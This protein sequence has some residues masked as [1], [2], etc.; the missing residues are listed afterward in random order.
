MQASQGL[1]RRRQR[2]R[3]SAGR[4][5]SYHPLP[6]DHPV[7]ASGI[8]WAV[9]LLVLI[10]LHTHTRL[11]MHT[12]ARVHTHIG[13]GACACATP[14][15]HTH[16]H[17][18]TCT[19]TLGVG[20]TFVSV[21]TCA[22]ACFPWLYHGCTTAAGAAAVGDAARRRAAALRGRRT[23]RARAAEEAPAAPAA[24]REVRA[25]PRAALAAATRARWRRLL[26]RVLDV[27]QVAQRG[28]VEGV[29][30][31]WRCIAVYSYCTPLFQNVGRI[32]LQAQQR[33]TAHS[34]RACVPRQGLP[35]PHRIGPIKTSVYHGAIVLLDRHLRG[36]MDYSF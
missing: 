6:S 8:G 2:R 36:K 27:G 16:T 25:A 11:H 30:S 26:Q 14:C 34:H 15:A 10:P 18:H 22:C 33:P 5:P 28:V 23:A 20:R 17:T 19:C 31:E 32:A 3:A 9:G 21:C 12:H 29:S 1:P 4:L 35:V 13:V 24:G 7:E